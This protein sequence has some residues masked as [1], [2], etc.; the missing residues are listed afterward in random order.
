MTASSG[1]ACNALGGCDAAGEKCGRAQLADGTTSDACIWEEWCGALGREANAFFGI[2][3][4]TAVAEGETPTAPANVDL[5]ANFAAVE[6]LI[7]KTTVNWDS[8]TDIMVS[9]RFNYQD[10][11]FLK[12]DT[13]WAE[14]DKPSDNRCFLDLQ[15][16]SDACCANYPD[17]NNRRCIPKVEHAV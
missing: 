14:Y 17:T 8:E 3:C 16:D 2:N 7:T 10:G 11:W 4:W 1:A 15:C 9:P 13:K 5:A 6:S 12:E